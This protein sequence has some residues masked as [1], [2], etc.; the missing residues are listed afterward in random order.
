MS[1]ADANAFRRQPYGLLLELA[2]TL[3]QNL[4]AGIAEPHEIDAYVQVQL[5]LAGRGGLELILDARD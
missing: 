3:E 1:D 4:I 2:Y 5:E